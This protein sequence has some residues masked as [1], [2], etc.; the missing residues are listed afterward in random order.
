MHVGII[1]ISQ[2]AA[3]RKNSQML[4]GK[5]VME[6]GQVGGFEEEVILIDDDTDVGVGAQGGAIGPQIAG[7]CRTDENNPRRKI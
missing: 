7:G 3:L 5:G 6:P 4:R 2:V 1:Q